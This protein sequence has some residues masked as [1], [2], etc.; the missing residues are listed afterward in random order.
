MTYTVCARIIGLN[1]YKT[2]R[3]IK[4]AFLNDAN[5]VAMALLSDPNIDVWIMRG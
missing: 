5:R 3:A 1:G 2:L 4:F